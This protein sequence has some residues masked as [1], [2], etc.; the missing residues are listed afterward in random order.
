[1]TKLLERSEDIPDADMNAIDAI[2]IL[3][4]F[5]VPD[6]ETEYKSGK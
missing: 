2:L 3:C 1:V 5:L 6:P 4:A